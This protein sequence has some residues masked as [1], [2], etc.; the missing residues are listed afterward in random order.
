[1][2]YKCPRCSY[3]FTGEVGYC[4]NCGLKL[5]YHKPEEQEQK[6]ET[7]DKPFSAFVNKPQ[8]QESKPNPAIVNIL[9]V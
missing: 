9:L 2:K 8:T 7:N 1:M 4:P 3:V 5:K 6:N